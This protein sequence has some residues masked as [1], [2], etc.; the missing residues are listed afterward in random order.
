M[1]V[2]EAFNTMLMATDWPT[3]DDNLAANTAALGENIHPFLK[4]SLSLS[5]KSLRPTV[6]SDLVFT[7]D[8]APV[9]FIANSLVLR[10]ALEGGAAQFPAQP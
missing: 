10:F 3:S 1:D 4:H 5:Q 8:R 2:P 7:D 6:A 9:E